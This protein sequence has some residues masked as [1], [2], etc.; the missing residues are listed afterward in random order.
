MHNKSKF[1]ET[2]VLKILQNERKQIGVIVAT[3]V[4]FGISLMMFPTMLVKAK[5]LPKPTAD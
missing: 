2:T 4:I 5:L 1:I 3:L